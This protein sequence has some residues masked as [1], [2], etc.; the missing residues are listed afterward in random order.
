MLARAPD[1]AAAAPAVLAG[2]CG[3]LDWQVAGLWLFDPEDQRLRCIAQWNA[4][5]MAA[6]AFERMTRE[7]RF[8]PGVGLP[9]RVFATGAV[10]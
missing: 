8:P 4:P 2:I 5:A 3:N 7:A 1:L 6:P 10:A 9:G